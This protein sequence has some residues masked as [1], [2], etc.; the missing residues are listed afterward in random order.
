MKYHENNPNRNYLLI[1]L[2]AAYT[3]REAVSLTQKNPQDYIEPGLAYLK[4]VPAEGEMDV[5]FKWICTEV[6]L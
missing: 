1:R 4:T 3:R 6:R 5:H 2:F